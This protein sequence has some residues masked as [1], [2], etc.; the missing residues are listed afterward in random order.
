MTSSFRCPYLEAKVCV[1]YEK[2]C[3]GID[4]CG[5]GSDEVSCSND[6]EEEAEKAQPVGEPAGVGTPGC[7]PNQYQCQ[8][9]KCIPG[10]DKCNHRYDCDDG[11]DETVCGHPVRIASDVGLY[12]C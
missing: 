3:D 4:D 10:S 8:D 12:P 11:S 7:E 5:D 6:I 1:H 2:I 9:G